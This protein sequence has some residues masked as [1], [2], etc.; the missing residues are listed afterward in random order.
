M[1]KLFRRGSR[2][3]G[4]VLEVID[5]AARRRRRPLSAACAD[6]LRALVNDT[7]ARVDARLEP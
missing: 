5:K 2:L 6:A 4:R 3:V 7:K 1:R